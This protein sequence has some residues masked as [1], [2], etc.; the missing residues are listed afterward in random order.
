ME[1]SGRFGQLGL[2][3][4]Q[5]DSEKEK[6]EM[7][8]PER[9]SYLDNS[10]EVAFEQLRVYDGIRGEPGSFVETFRQKMLLPI[11]LDL[12]PPPSTYP[13]SPTIRRGSSTS[14]ENDR[15]S[16]G[17]LLGHRKPRGQSPTIC[18]FC[19]MNG[20]EA[21]FHRLKDDSG[22]VVC[23]VLYK[24]RCKLC[25]ATGRDA[26]TQKFCPRNPITRGDPIGNNVRPGLMPTWLTFKKLP[27][28]E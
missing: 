14:S 24:F 17:S 5:E 28:C 16:S 9:L 1:R 4:A 10:I 15:L 11:K 25:G 3:L 20:E 19:K 13:S 6:G 2:I 8:T 26:H 7:W 12:N 21:I 18:K 22:G 23:P 27:E